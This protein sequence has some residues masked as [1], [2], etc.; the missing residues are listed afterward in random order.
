MSHTANEPSDEE[1]EDVLLSCRYGDLED[2]EQFVAKYGANVL[3]EIRDEN[4]NTALH[5]AC[6]NGH[7]GD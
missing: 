4:G 2:I 6:G 5:M 1:R 7:E 3:S